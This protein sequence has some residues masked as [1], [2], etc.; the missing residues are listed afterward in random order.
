MPSNTSEYLPRPAR[1]VSP[2][3]A[4][5]NCPP[6]YLAHD[7]VVVEHAPGYVDAVVVP[8]RPRHLLVDVGVD[9]RHWEDS[10]AALEAGPVVC[11][12]R[13]RGSCGAGCEAARAVAGGSSRVG[14]RSWRQGRSEVL[15]V[16]DF[17]AT[18]MQRG[19]DSIRESRRGGAQPG[20]PPGSRPISASDALS[21]LVAAREPI[22]TTSGPM[23]CLA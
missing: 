12:C 6:T 1:P 8:V 7:L 19:R 10:A 20:L 2:L 17:V 18:E 4:R 14:A 21:L 3:L 15:A 5:G 13:L 11:G 23:V 16:E 22:A 9:A